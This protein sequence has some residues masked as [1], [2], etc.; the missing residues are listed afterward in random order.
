MALREKLYKSVD[1]IQFHTYLP[2]VTF[3]RASI[4]SNRSFAPLSDMQHLL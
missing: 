1:V 4:Y 3:H 2:P